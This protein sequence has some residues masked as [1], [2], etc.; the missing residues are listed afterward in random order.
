[1]SNDFL[2]VARIKNIDAFL[3]LSELADSFFFTSNHLMS[4]HRVPRICIQKCQYTTCEVLCLDLLGS[5]NHTLRN[6]KDIIYSGSF[7]LAVVLYDCV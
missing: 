4:V 2:A 6:R 1:M 5:F 7:Y 3:V